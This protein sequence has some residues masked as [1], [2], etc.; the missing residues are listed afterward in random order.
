MMRIIFFIGFLER[1][2]LI[3]LFL[4]T[5]LCNYIPYFYYFL[6]MDRG[7]FYIFFCAMLIIQDLYL[8][9]LCYFFFF[10]DTMFLTGKYGKLS[11]LAL[12]R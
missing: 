9:I 11:G 4:F 1:L 3:L 10:P 2:I 7:I 6:H 12:F 8:Y 5:I